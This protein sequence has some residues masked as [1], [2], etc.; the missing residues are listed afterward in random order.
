MAVSI[1]SLRND[2]L[3]ITQQFTTL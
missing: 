2:A 3:S 1:V